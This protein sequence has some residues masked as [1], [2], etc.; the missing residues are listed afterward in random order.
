MKVWTLLAHP[1]GFRLPLPVAIAAKAVNL[2]PFPAAEP[3]ELLLSVEQGRPPCRQRCWLQGG[4]MQQGPG[5]VPPR[6]DHDQMAAAPIKPE[7]IG[8]GATGIAEAG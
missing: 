7:Q 2:P 5:P 6:A 1:P 4:L 3:L 8:L